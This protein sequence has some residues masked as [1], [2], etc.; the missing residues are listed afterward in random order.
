[1][2]QLTFVRDNQGQL[3]VKIVNNI[4]LQADG[5]TIDITDGLLE[6]ALKLNIFQEKAYAR[7]YENAYY[8]CGDC[9]LLRV[10]RN[11]VIIIDSYLGDKTE[12]EFGL[13][14]C[15]DELDGVWLAEIFKNK[16]V[17]IKRANGHRNSRGIP[18]MT[19]SK[20]TH[21]GFEKDAQGRYRMRI[22]TTDNY[23]V[24]LA[25]IICAL[26]EGRMNEVDYKSNW[27]FNLNRMELHHDGFDWDNRLCQTMYLTEQEHVDYHSQ[28]GEWS[29][30]C[31]C[32]ITTIEEL[33]AFLEFIQC[34][35]VMR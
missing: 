3:K 4:G 19:L 2:K 21:Q 26:N 14:N 27:S 6:E 33:K 12:S 29:H 15:A 1:M 32:K 30:Q 7:G 17:S 34:Y 18:R 24:E 5:S 35:K 16:S 28:V 22:K 9:T 13:D 10:R 11:Q 8:K 31:Y 20:V 25:T 23:P